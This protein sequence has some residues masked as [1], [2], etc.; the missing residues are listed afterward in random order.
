MTHIMVTFIDIVI[1]FFNW[2]IP[3]YDF[4]SNIYNA[5][6]DSIPAVVSFLTDCNFIIPLGDIFVIIAT[7]CT[8]KLF[9]LIMFFGNWTVNKITDIIPL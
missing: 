6:A 4:E 9:R 7:S 3:S 5:I 8:W 2:V 1:N